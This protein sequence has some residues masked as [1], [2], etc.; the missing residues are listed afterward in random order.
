M[1]QRQTQIVLIGS[2][3]F[4]SH[5]Q[6]RLGPVDTLNSLPSA[7]SVRQP[8]VVV[9]EL[10]SAEL[11]R[12][13]QA[14]ACRQ[15]WPV[16]G[17][18]E[19]A[20]PG[21]VLH[22]WLPP[23]CTTAQVRF[24]VERAG[25]SLADAPAAR[26]DTGRAEHRFRQVQEMSLLL[27]SSRHFDELF[28]GVIRHVTRIMEVDRTS[29][30][31]L[32]EAAGQLWTKVA[33]GV[34]DQIRIPLGVGLAG[35]CASD[36]RPLRVNDVSCHA[37]FDPSWDRQLGYTTERVLC[38]PVFNRS[39]ELKGVLQMINKCH[40]PFDGED[41][42]LAAVCAAQVGMAL[43]NFQLLEELRQGF[44]SF[45][46]AL[47]ETLD[48]K[49]R[50]TAGHSHRVTE[51]ALF[52]GRALALDEQ[53]LD[54]LK[55][56]ALLHDLGKIAVPDRVLTKNGRFTAEEFAVMQSHPGWSGR[57][58]ERMLLPRHLAQLPQLASSHHER[59]DGSGYPHGAR[60]EAI[61]Y[62]ARIIAVADVFDA[63]SSKRDYPKYDQRGE[64]DLGYGPL[65]LERV[66]TMISEDAGSH[67]DAEV[68]AAALR[69]RNALEQLCRQLHEASRE[70]CHD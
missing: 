36:R 41:D 39:Q 20:E 4:V 61:P 8:Q 48:A 51:Y 10:S 26:S 13:Q 43:E 59:L 58:L 12:W 46:R 23:H 66:F 19:E 5:W 44:E 2:Q 27:N 28:Q 62:L 47:T 14:G 52:L 9:A 33:E 40:G 7:E 25:L 50:L 60:G 67:L 38:F 68:V 42:E 54:V 32:D 49:H 63:L 35:R 56:A 31:L 17:I 34:T 22:S 70:E 45:I 3:P 1:R 16:V 69:E 55:Y 29:L 6:Q 18:G 64:T 57:I 11:S 15:R 53:T 21:V 24:A 65:E 30:F 37:D